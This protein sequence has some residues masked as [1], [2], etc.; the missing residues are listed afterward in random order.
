M[1]QQIDGWFEGRDVT[2]GLAFLVL[3]ERSVRCGSWEGGFEQLVV[4][5]KFAGTELR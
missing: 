1:M 3:R 5:R 4:V 2:C